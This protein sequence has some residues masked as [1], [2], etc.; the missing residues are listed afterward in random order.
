MSPTW[1]WFVS[2]WRT[3]TIPQATTSW[4]S[5]RC[6]SRV[7][8]QVSLQCSLAITESVQY[9]CSPDLLSCISAG[10]RHVRL[11]KQDGSRRSPSSI[12][13][14]VKITPCQSS[15]SKSS[16]KSPAVSPAKS[17]AKKPWSHL[18]PI[19]PWSSKAS[20]EHP[21]TCLIQA[22]KDLCSNS[23]TYMVITF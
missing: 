22:T 3:M 14:H 17:S 4:D 11:L 13:I 6:P 20:R 1:L 9:I 16:A 19:T 21:K 7:S 2:W 23:K 12:F 5:T 10:Y 15:P 18:Y 8:V